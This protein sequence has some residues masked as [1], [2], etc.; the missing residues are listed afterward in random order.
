MSDARA[1]LPLFP[2]HTVLFPQGLLP[3]KV[4]EMRYID[5]VRECMKDDAPFGVVRIKSGHEVGGAAE[6]DQIGCLAEIRHW[7][8]RETGILLLKVEG[9]A[10]FRILETRVLPNQRIEARIEM[11]AADAAIPTN[12][13]HLACAQ[14]LKPIIEDIQQRERDEPGFVSPFPETAHLDDAAWVANR[15]SEILPI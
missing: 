14:A 13:M 1:W 15:W 8:M 4:F 11:I 12:A 2:L 10:R 6:P 5:M 9:Q 3:L 7:D